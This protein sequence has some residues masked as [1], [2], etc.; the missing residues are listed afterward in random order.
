MNITSIENKEE[1]IDSQ[2]KAGI[3]KQKVKK[4]AFVV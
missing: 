2:K 4:E 3:F 1:S